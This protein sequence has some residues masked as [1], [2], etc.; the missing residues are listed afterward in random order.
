ML[1]H[2]MCVRMRVIQ[3]WYTIH[4][5]KKKNGPLHYF[6]SGLHV[7][8]LNITLILCVCVC[9]VFHFLKCGCYGA[10]TNKSRWCGHIIGVGRNHS[11]FVLVPIKSAN[12][13]ALLQIHVNGERIA[14]NYQHDGVASSGDKRHRQTAIKIVRPSIIDLI[15]KL[16]F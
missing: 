16:L 10:D 6:G 12:C 5:F 7:L 11:V 13:C 1:F 2:Y 14:A 8:F 4:L 15:L 9:V 3:R